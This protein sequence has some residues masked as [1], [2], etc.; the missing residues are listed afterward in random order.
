MKRYSLVCVFL[1]SVLFLA[2]CGTKT[3]GVK[4]R[5]HPAH[6][7]E[8]W[9]AAGPITGVNEAKANGALEVHCFQDG[10]CAHVVRLNI[11]PPEQGLSYVAW[12]QGEDEKNIVKIGKLQNPA[13]DV[14]YVLNG[15]VKRDFSA[16]MK[17]IVTVEE[18]D[19]VAA[20]GKHVAEGTLKEFPLAD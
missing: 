9:V 12:V 8:T 14:R 15:E 5:M 2:A 1:S 10:F 20:P 18:S 11:Y 16:L 19:D 4:P 6:G 17:I 13:G 3:A 7:T